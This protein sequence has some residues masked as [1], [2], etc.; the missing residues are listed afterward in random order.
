VSP[1]SAGPEGIHI[2]KAPALG[3]LLEQ[4]RFGSYNERVESSPAEHGGITF[5][6]FEKEM[7]A[8]KLKWI[9]ERLRADEEK[10]AV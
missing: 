8:F 5:A 9:Y 4:P 3:L 1:N 6:P 2:P 10:M 7:K